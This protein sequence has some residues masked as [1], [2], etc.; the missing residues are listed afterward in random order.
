MEELNDYKKKPNFTEASMNSKRST[1]KD[2]PKT[3]KIKDQHLHDGKSSIV[4]RLCNI[5]TFI[6]GFFLFIDILDTCRLLNGLAAGPNSPLAA[7]ILAIS[8]IF[9]FVYKKVQVK[10]ILWA[11]IM[12]YTI[13]I[14]L[15]LID[16]DHPDDIY[17]VILF[18]PIG[19]F[20]LI[21]DCK[22][23]NK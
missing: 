6:A 19:L 15:S 1:F 2:I 22:S 5:T 10:I 16:P 8:I 12:F 14:F 7:L 17:A 4:M 20:A 13:G 21:F 3:T 11:F 9:F 23:N 18:V